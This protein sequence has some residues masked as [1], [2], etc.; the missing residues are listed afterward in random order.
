[1]FRKISKRKRLNRCKKTF[2]ELEWILI[3]CQQMSLTCESD[4]EYVIERQTQ[5][6]LSCVTFSPDRWTIVYSQPPP[7]IH[8][9]A[10][11]GRRVLI[12]LV[13]TSTPDVCNGHYPTFVLS[14]SGKSAKICIFLTMKSLGS[15]H[16]RII[17]TRQRN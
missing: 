14:N 3:T 15:V 5:L 12:N 10:I 8:R 6:G 11:R 1:M 16:T 4:S 7:P 9:R 17:L 2:V 13:N